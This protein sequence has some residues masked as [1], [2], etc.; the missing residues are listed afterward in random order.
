MHKTVIDKK[1]LLQLAVRE[2]KV[3]V[4]NKLIAAGVDVNL[5][6]SNGVTPLLIAACKGHHEV[7]AA[8][9]VHGANVDIA[10]NNERTVFHSDYQ[11]SDEIKNTLALVSSSQPLRSS[12]NA[13]L[14]IDHKLGERFVN[15]LS[16]SRIFL[17]VKNLIYTTVL[18]SV[19]LSGLASEPQAALPFLPNEL[20]L[21]ILYI[22]STFWL[23]KEGKI[24]SP[25]GIVSEVVAANPALNFSIKSQ[26]VT[27]DWRLTG[28]G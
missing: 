6:E 15:G 17:K 1:H 8:L 13:Q 20:W 25:L 10:D 7:V 3:E 22:A 28:G 26:S 21:H 24:D 19:R 11:V 12:N 16:K 2:G 27:S 23:N 9:I 5:A 18:S 14:Y 4:V